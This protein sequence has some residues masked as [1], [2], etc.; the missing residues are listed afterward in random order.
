MRFIASPDNNIKIT[1]QSFLGAIA[2][3]FDVMFNIS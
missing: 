3:T 2:A 1:K